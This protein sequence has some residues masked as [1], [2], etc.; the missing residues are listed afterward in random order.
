VSAVLQVLQTR[1]QI[2][3]IDLSNNPFYTPQVPIPNPRRA[4]RVLLLLLLNSLFFL[5]FHSFSL[6]SVR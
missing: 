6:F 5:S 3:S 2:T 4:L 1:Q